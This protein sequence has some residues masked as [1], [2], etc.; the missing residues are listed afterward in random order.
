MGRH[1]WYTFFIQYLAKSF[2]NSVLL[3]ID[4]RLIISSQLKDRL[5]CCTCMFHKSIPVTCHLSLQ[6]VALDFPLFSPGRVITAEA[7]TGAT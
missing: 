6:T 4:Y 7:L 5:I 1:F 2:P 3:C